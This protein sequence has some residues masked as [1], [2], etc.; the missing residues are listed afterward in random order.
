MGVTM[1]LPRAN[2]QLMEAKTQNAKNPL[3]L[4]EE[5]LA[6]MLTILTPTKQPSG[7]LTMEK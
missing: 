2:L 5:A 6:G 7:N 4:K 1:A 3:M